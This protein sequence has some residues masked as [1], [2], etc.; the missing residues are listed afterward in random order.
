MSIPFSAPA[1]KRLAFFIIRPPSAL[2]HQTQPSEL[3][4]MNDKQLP[5][6]SWILGISSKCF[7][8]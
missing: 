8:F 6:T 3:M 2:R 4:A 1:K 5:T 7:Y